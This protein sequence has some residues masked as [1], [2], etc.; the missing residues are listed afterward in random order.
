MIEQQKPKT[1]YY[2]SNLFR[3]RYWQFVIAGTIVIAMLPLLLGLQWLGVF[4]MY[5]MPLVLGWFWL[6]QQMACRHCGT[7][8]RVTR[9]TGGQEVCQK[10]QQPTDK[11]LQTRTLFP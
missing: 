6:T 1:T 9:L 10:C 4:L 11:Q 8:L 5:F 3:W 7:V 2:L